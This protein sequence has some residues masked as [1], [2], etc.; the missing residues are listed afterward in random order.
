M[1]PSLLLLSCLVG[2]VA[3]SSLSYGIFSDEF[4]ETVNERATTWQAGRNFHSNTPRRFAEQLQGTFVNSSRIEFPPRRNYLLQDMINLPKNFDSRSAWPNCPSITE[5]R[6]Q[7]GCGSCWAFGAVEVMSDRSCIASNGNLNIRYSAEDLLTCCHSCGAGCNG[8]W[9][10]KAFQ[11]WNHIGIVSGGSFNST[12]GCRPYEIEPCEHHVSGPR[13]SCTGEEGPTPRCKR[14]CQDGYNHM[15]NEDRHRA[16][17]VYSLSSDENEIQH[18]IRTHG[19]VEG[20]FT[21]YEDFLHY[22][23]GVYQ[24]VHGRPLGGHAI[25]VLGWGEENGVKFWLCANSW[26]SDWGDSGFFKILR[27]SNHCGIEGEMVSGIPQV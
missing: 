10:G 25:R 11:Y 23:S 22:K 20:A 12:E 6:D 13:P 2:L 26:N 7:G 9:P 8:G 18:D 14:S 19:P 4:L 17:E 21:V 16:R 15:Y 1:I 27:G 24:H 3:P 5:I